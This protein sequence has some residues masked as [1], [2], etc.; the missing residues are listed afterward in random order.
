MSVIL[1]FSPPPGPGVC[2]ATFC[3]FRFRSV[4]GG[5]GEVENCEER[6]AMDLGLKSV[7]LQGLVDLPEISAKGHNKGRVLCT[8][9]AAMQRAK[10]QLKP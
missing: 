10:R 6:I 3:C 1:R 8:L 4:S 7:T 2:V 9:S 5:G